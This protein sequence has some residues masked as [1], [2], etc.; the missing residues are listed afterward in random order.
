MQTRTSACG[1]SLANPV[2][3][4]SMPDGSGASTDG[5]LSRL[6][7]YLA[8]QLGPFSVHYLM[9]IVQV[10]LG[11]SELAGVVSQWPTLVYM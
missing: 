2:F 10:L 4:A 9:V 5:W 3:L 11:Y 8:G 7:M 1:V 6:C